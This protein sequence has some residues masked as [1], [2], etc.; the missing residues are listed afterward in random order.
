MA[1]LYVRLSSRIG[2]ML[3]PEVRA[4]YDLLGE[5]QRLRVPATGRLEF[6]RTW[7]LLGRLLPPAP[8]RVLDVGGATGI[9]AGPLAA[10]GYSVHVVDPVPGHV[11]AAAALP[12]VTAALGDARDL[13]ETADESVDAVLLLG[14]LYHL[15]ERADRISAWREAARVL[16][17]DGV[18]VAATIGR[19][20][21]AFDGFVKGFYRQDGYAALVDET[22][23][24]GMHRP[25]PRPWFTTAYF[26]RPAEAAGEA[27]EAGLAVE[28]VVSIEGP[29]WTVGRLREVL[30]DAVE[31][32]HLLAL[33][34]RIEDDPA[35]LAATSHLMTIARRPSGS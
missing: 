9:Y 17:P 12:G 32:A 10:A 4:Y 33:L 19:Y 26:H 24:S 22:L 21:S 15:P 5:Q 18:V 27:A 2:R 29:L 31:T 16:R 6:L 28:R 34:R 7:D 13:A 23:E 1:L 11:S 8:A 25:G 14:P 20:A 35:L 30:D 3:E